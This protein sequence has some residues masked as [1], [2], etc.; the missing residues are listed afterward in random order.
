[1]AYLHIGQNVML[2]EK[3]IIG[4]FDLDNTTVSKK[5]R[6]F[7]NKAQKEKRVIYEGFELPKSFLVCSSKKSENK[8]YLS[9]L[10]STT[11]Q[12]RIEKSDIL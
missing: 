11:L 5:S 2:E 4:L 1:M 7:L 12:K 10:N 8:V 3:R 9:V 6:D